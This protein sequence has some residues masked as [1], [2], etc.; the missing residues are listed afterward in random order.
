M[1][2]HRGQRH[3]H[4]QLEVGVQGHRGPL[5]ALLL[6]SWCC[7]SSLSGSTLYVCVGVSAT[8]LMVSMRGNRD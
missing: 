4:I 8:T 7:R 2:P 6:F 5:G 3:P 1:L